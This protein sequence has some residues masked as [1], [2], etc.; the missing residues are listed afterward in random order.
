MPHYWLTM[1]QST[2]LLKAA[3]QLHLF[4]N[5]FLAKLHQLNH[6]RPL[7]KKSVNNQKNNFIGQTKATVKTNQETIELPLLITKAQTDPLMEL[8]WM[9]Q[10]KT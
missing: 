8:D 5:A 3:H 1:N 2:L 6:S 7:I 9:Q 10:L 4:R